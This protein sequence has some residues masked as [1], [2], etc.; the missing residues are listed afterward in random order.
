VNGKSLTEIKAAELADVRQRMAVE[1]A[2]QLERARLDVRPHDLWWHIGQW[3]RRFARIKKA[4][5]ALAAAITAVGAV[6]TAI[7]GIRTWRT[8]RSVAPP[9]QPAPSGGAST[10]LDRVEKPTTAKP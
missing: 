1:K 7:N 2:E 6:L 8:S 9:E 10:A 3:T 5:S 4:V